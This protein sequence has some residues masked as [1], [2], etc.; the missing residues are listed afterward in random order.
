MRQR[1]GSATEM[2]SARL[3]DLRRFAPSSS[4]NDTPP[5]DW[6]ISPVCTLRMR[7]PS[8]THALLVPAKLT[9]ASLLVVFSRLAN[10]ARGGATYSPTAYMVKDKVRPARA[11]GQAIL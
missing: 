2:R 11:T 4:Y 9:S 8:F 7:L 3:I 6:S 1:P 5:K 10:C